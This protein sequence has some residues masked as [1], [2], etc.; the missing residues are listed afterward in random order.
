MKTG[1]ARKPRLEPGKRRRLGPL[2]PAERVLTLL[3]WVGAHVPSVVVSAVIVLM[4]VGLLPGL[5]AWLLLG[6]MALGSVLMATRWM[7]WPAVGWFLG[8]SR[9][10][11][12]VDAAIRPLLEVVACVSDARHGEGAARPHER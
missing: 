3:L 11:A 1:I 4:I 5:I 7:R 8:G 9:L 10:A 12:D 2:S 6:A